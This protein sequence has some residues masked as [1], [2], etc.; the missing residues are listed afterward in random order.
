M[1]DK[2][3]SPA[4]ANQTGLQKYST[5]ILMPKRRNVKREPYEREDVYVCPICGELLDYNEEVYTT[6]DGNVIGC[7]C[8]IEKHDAQYYCKEATINDLI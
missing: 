7:E 8:C 2:K 1:L 5:N 4:D 6:P 3:G